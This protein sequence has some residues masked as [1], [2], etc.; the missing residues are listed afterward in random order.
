M[1][2]TEG[3]GSKLFEIV[4]NFGD[5]WTFKDGTIMSQ[6]IDFS[7]VFLVVHHTV[8]L[9]RLLRDAPNT[10]NFFYTVSRPLSYTFSTFKLASGSICAN[11][12]MMIVNVKEKMMQS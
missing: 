11:K 3:N 5:S 6:R 4:T 1:V 9:S 12:P 8:N 7:T 2:P 10:H